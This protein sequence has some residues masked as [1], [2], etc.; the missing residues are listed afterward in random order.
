[1]TL[2]FNGV[3]FA[4]GWTLTTKIYTTYMEEKIFSFDDYDSY[5]GFDDEEEGI[6]DSMEEMDYDEEYDY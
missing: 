2:V 1:M 4:K 5:D 6:D 3:Y